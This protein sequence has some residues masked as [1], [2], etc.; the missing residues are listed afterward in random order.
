M[1]SQ[2]NFACHDKVRIGG[3][4]ICDPLRIVDLA[5]EYRRNNIKPKRRRKKDQPYTCVVYTSG[6]NEIEFGEQY[7]DYLRSR[8]DEMHSV[9]VNDLL[10][11]EIH[12]FAPNAQ[13]GFCCY[14]A[15]RSC[16]SGIF[17]L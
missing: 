12:V 14:A 17:I 11:C 2:I 3:Y 4:W 1:H 16:F 9:Q 10:A 13:V 6:R 8:Q 7:F 5:N 15:N